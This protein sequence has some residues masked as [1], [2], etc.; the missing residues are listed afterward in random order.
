MTIW[1]GAGAIPAERAADHVVWVDDSDHLDSPALHDG[2]LVLLYHVLWELTHVC[3]EHPGLL[4]TDD[5]ANCGDDVCITCS[6][7]GRI[8]EVIAAE[9][10][11]RARVRTA[12]GIETIDTTIVTAVVPGDLVLIHAGAAISEIP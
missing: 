7:E 10:S 6:D 2:R 1:M 12:K 4:R 5:E 9:G 8:G 11:S 3:F